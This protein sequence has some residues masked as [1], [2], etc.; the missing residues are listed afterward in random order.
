[1]SFIQE[2]PSMPG[3]LPGEIRSDGISMEYRWNIGWGA[4]GRSST[5]RGGL[6]ALDGAEEE[7]Q[8]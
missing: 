8:V 1:M 3:A 5:G 6:G 2:L 4:A 7:A